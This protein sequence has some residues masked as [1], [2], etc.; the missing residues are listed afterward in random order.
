MTYICECVSQWEAPDKYY[1]R[2]TKMLK[3]DGKTLDGIDEVRLECDACELK[4][5]LRNVGLNLYFSGTYVFDNYTRREELKA[6]GVDSE[7]TIRI[8][9]TAKLTLEIKT[10]SDAVEAG[11]ISDTLVIS[12]LITT[13]DGGETYN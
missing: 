12:S 9:I 2:E 4:D 5:S 7:R 13:L 8:P 1:S 11:K 6:V 10:F 3:S